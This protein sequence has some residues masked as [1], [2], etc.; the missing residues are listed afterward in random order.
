MGKENDPRLTDT[1]ETTETGFI[2]DKELE[3][4]TGGAG[5]GSPGGAGIGGGAHGSGGTI[6]ITGG[7]ITRGR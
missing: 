2:E 6:N 7:T 3:A 5:E 4:V 1:K